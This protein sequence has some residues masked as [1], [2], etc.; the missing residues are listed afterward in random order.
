MMAAALCTVITLLLIVSSDTL[1]HWAVIPIWLCGI[2]V[3]I[4]AIDWVRRRL[5][6]FDPVGIVGVFGFYYFFIAP[7]LHI[8]WEYWTPA[9]SPPED[10][11]ASM[12]SMAMFNLVGLL[13]YRFVRNIPVQNA[14]AQSPTVWRL[15]KP[16]FVTVAAVM[17]FIT[18]AMQIG[19]YRQYGGISGYMDAATNLENPGAMRGMGWIFLIS[20]SFP[21]LAMMLFAV[22]VKERKISKSWLILGGA[23]VAFIVLRVFFGGLKGSRS[24][25]IFATI[26]AVG[27]VH[28]Y[29]RFIPRQ[30]VLVG[31]SIILAF[32]YFYGFYKGAGPRAVEALTS[33]SARAALSEETGRDFPGLLL[34]D[35]SRSDIQAFVFDKVWLTRGGYIDNYQYS[36]GRTYVGALALLVPRSLW[37]NRP[38][39]KVEEGTSIRYGMGTY[40]EDEV[41]SSKLFGLAGEAMLN[42]GPLAIPFAFAIWGLVV[43]YVRRLLL[44]LEP[45]DSRLLMFPFLILLCMIMLT[46]DSDNI[47]FYII[48]NGSIPFLVLFF[49]SRIF[50]RRRRKVVYEASSDGVVSNSVATA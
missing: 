5:P 9:P 10:W 3:T 31:V 15:N 43:G 14:A 44:G 20:E 30:M 32:M 45:G 36:W 37:P 8:M 11:N 29:V 27:I 18:A 41:W 17:L 4:D 48:Q 49:S 6:L 25:M 2:I 23:V 46:A 12:G 19:V 50:S 39:A 24:A 21:I 40:I 13:I 7:L 22:Q 28:L 1:M 35:L 38:N 16:K 47:V 26:W 42:F 33:S 34:G